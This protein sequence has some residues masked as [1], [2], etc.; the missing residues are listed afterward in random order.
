MEIYQNLSLEDLPNEVWKDVPN[1]EGL[2]QAS[3]LGRI[4]S[5]PRLDRLGREVKG[6]IRKQTM[7]NTGYLC[8]PL[9]AKEGGKKTLK[10]YCVHRLIAE[11]FL[12]NLDNKPCIDHIN[13]VKTDNRVENLKWVTYQ[14]NN[15]NPITKSSMQQTMKDLSCTEE[16]KKKIE[17]LVLSSKT[18]AAKAKWRASFK[19]PEV[20]AKITRA[21]GKPVVQLTFEGQFVAEYSCIREAHEKTGACHIGDVCSGKRHWAGGYLWKFKETK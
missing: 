4:K 19:R 1:Y 3:N 18:E 10:L 15:N 5:L 14:E 11:T 17:R 13:T 7:A 12:P 9:Y 20:L 21:H 16:G 8:V 6:G 2:Y